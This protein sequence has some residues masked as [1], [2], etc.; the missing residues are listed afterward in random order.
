MCQAPYEQVLFLRPSAFREATQESRLKS[1]TALKLHLH[2]QSNASPVFSIHLFTRH[3]LSKTGR[4]KKRSCKFIT[5]PFWGIGKN[6]WNGQ[7]EPKPRCI[8]VWGYP[9]ARQSK[10]CIGHPSFYDEG[11]LLRRCSSS[12]AKS[13]H[14]NTFCESAEKYCSQTFRLK[15]GAE[16]KMSK[17]P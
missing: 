1:K 8:A 16:Y 9:K 5:A 13:F 6:V 17:T 7:T 2:T 3:F 12:F 10:R 15:G 14:R 4:N 11:F